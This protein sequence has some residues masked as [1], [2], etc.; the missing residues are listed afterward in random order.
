MQSPA[1]KF[2]EDWYR[3][4][5]W[6]S[7]PFQIDLAQAYFEGYN[8]LLNAPTGSGKTYAMWIPILAEE[9]KRREEE[10]G[11]RKEGGERR[12]AVTNSFFLSPFS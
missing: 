5:N 1:M 3:R 2:I 8:G 11:R 9:L 10:G 6:R 4:K 7:Y 12:R